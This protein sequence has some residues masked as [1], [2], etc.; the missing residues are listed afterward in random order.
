MQERPIPPRNLQGV[1]TPGFVQFPKD[2][3]VTVA[4]GT[5]IAYTVK[6]GPRLPILLANGW[7]CSDAYWVGVLP[8]LVE[9]GH[10]VVLPDHRGHGES[11]LPRDP[12]P[13]ARDIS[14]DDLSVERMAGDLIAVL[15]DAGIEQAALVGH[16]M[17]VQVILETY[18]KAPERV[19]AL[20]A[21][22]GAFENPLSTFYGMSWDR[23][24][25]P[26][27]QLMG[28]I[29]EPV[30]RFGLQG[31]RLPRFGHAMARLVRAAGPKAT[32]AGLAPYLAHLATRNPQVLFKAIEGMRRHSAG[33]LLPDIDV[34]TLILAAGQDVFTPPRC[35][36]AMAEAVP[37]SEIVWFDD[38]G[39]TLPIEEPDAI[40]D[41]ID[42]FIRRRVSTTAATTT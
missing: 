17:G 30:L 18:R 28:F 12:G 3:K 42:D 23:V 21:V 34:P 1:D 7:S 35:Q 16:S 41:A 14:V 24:F 2:R 20:V 5:P 39:H 22:A 37:D 40:V 29:P 32:A 10:R 11:G 8:E 38:A 31:G 6:D 15:D 9:R 33:D 13:N 25:P 27:L 19:A 36:K 26:V 4:D